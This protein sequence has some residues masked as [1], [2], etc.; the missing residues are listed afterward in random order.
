M[1]MSTLSWSMSFTVRLY[2][3]TIE[4][5]RAGTRVLLQF[6][7]LNPVLPVGARKKTRSVLST[8]IASSPHMDFHPGGAR[9]TLKPGSIGLHSPA[10]VC[11]NDYALSDLLL[12]LVVPVWPPEVWGLC[13]E[14][15]SSL[16]DFFD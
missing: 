16:L 12:P 3:G 13:P 4:F 15:L 2:S 8:T 11:I 7:R 6:R 10:L 1:F 14:G 5:V 9:K